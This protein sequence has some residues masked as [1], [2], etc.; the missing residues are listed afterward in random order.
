MNTSS[1]AVKKGGSMGESVEPLLRLL[2]SGELSIV[3]IENGNGVAQP[4][5]NLSKIRVQSDGI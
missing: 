5:S 4:E 3:L 1:P 2:R